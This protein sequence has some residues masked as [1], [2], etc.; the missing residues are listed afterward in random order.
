MDAEEKLA[1]QV[2]P[3]A[4]PVGELATVPG[5]KTLTLMGYTFSPEPERETVFG[6]PAVLLAIVKV[7]FRAPTAVGVNTTLTVQKLAGRMADTQLLLCEKSPVTDT[8]LTTRLPEP[9]LVTVTVW[10]TLLVF[11]P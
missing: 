2:V 9:V 7:P 6:L 3:Q 1:E 4:I 11:S 10:T 8:L 5:P